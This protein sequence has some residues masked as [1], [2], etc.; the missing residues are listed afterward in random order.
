MIKDDEKK[1]EATAWLAL[2]L[3]PEGEG[4]DATTSPTDVVEGIPLTRGPVGDAG[5]PRGAPR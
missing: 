3:V 1:K 2:C 5:G 4:D